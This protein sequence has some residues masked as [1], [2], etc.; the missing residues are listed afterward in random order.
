[1]STVKL[2]TPIEAYGEKVTEI[3]FRAPVGKDLRK[4]GL[5]NK[6]TIND[7]VQENHIDM[8]VMAK[9]M[10]LLGSIPASAVDALSM[11]DFLKCSEAVSDFFGQSGAPATSLNGTTM[12]PGSGG[13][14]PK[15]SSDMA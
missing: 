7:G 4:T 14:I 11:T 1:M 9:L 5:P 6:M 8:E 3:T 13:S 15:P 2:T 12:S 10:E